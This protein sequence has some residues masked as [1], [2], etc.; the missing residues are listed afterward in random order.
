MNKLEKVIYT[1]K[2]TSTGTL[3]SDSLC[4]INVSNRLIKSPL[5]FLKQIKLVIR[6]IFLQYVFYEI[7]LCKSI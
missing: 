5:I 1:A 6:G 4:Q 3:C 2:A 7:N